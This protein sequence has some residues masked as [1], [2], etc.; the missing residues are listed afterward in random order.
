MGRKFMGLAIVG[1][2]TAMISLVSIPSTSESSSSLAGLFGNRGG[3][4]GFGILAQNCGGGGGGG[5]LQRAYSS[6]GGG[7]GNLQ[8]APTGAYNGCSPVFGESYSSCGGVGGGGPG[9][10]YAMQYAQPTYAPAYYNYNYAPASNCPGGVCPPGM[11]GGLTYSPTY[12]APTYATASPPVPLNPGERYVAGSLRRVE[13]ASTI[14]RSESKAEPKP[15]AVSGISDSPESPKPV[16]GKL[17]ALP[18]GYVAYQFSQDGCHPCEHDQQKARQAGVPL[19]VLSFSDTEDAFKIAALARQIPEEI[20]GTPFYIV[21]DKDGKVQDRKQGQLK[22]FMS[23][24]RIA[25]GAKPVPTV[26]V[27]KETPPVDKM[28]RIEAALLELIS[29]TREARKETRMAMESLAAATR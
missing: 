14:A 19:T 24:V 5:G 18:N 25:Q 20:A 17:E 1:L 10:Q 6:C 3:P 8:Y 11:N 13:T 15:V 22:D 12:Y 29:E 16:R 2:T 7:G 21:V 27:A 26:Q 23:I 28:D 9:L 4:L